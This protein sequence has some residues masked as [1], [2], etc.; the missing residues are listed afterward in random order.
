MSMLPSINKLERA[1]K[2]LAKAHRIVP[3]HWKAAASF[4]PIKREGRNDGVPSDLQGPLKARDIRRTVTVLG[5]E[6]ECCSI[7]PDVVSPQRLPDCSVR[8]NPMNL[9]STVPKA[10]FSGLKCSLG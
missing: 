7:M 6:V 9:C 4:W 10:C 3:H 5:E 2:G 8:D 1:T